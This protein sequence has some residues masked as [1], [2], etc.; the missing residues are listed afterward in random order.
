AS[1][2]VAESCLRG[3][4]PPCSVPVWACDTVSGISAV[5]CTRPGGALWVRSGTTLDAAPDLRV[6]GPVGVW[7]RG[8]GGYCHGRGVLPGN[9]P[10]AEPSAAPDRGRT[11]RFSDP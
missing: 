5:R 10:D 11:G 8:T 9:V 3:G 1:W 6:G 2:S 4:S 7:G